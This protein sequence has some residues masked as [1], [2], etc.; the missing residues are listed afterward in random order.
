MIGSAGYSLYSLIAI[1]NGL[2]IDAIITLL[3]QNGAATSQHASSSMAIVLED[4]LGLLV[5]IG[6]ACMLSA[7]ACSAC[8]YMCPSATFSGVPEVMSY[9]NGVAMS[10]S[11]TLET[12]VYKF[13]S[14]AFAVSSGMPIGPEGPM[15]HIGAIIGRSI[16]YFLSGHEHGPSRSGGNGRT[17]KVKNIV[18][19]REERDF[20]IAGVGCGVAVAFGAPLGGLLFAFEE[21]SSG[22]GGSGISSGSSSGSGSLVWRTFLCCLCGV[23]TTNFLKSGEDYLL[24]ENRKF[25]SFDNQWSVA[26]EVH[27]LVDSHIYVVGISIFTGCVCGILGSL[28]TEG[29][30]RMTRMKRQ[31]FEKWEE[32]SVGVVAVEEER[33]RSSRLLKVL[34]V[35][36]VM[37]LFTSVSIL[38][39]ILTPCVEADC[40]ID[41]SGDY[42]CGSSK[43]T[44]TMSET[45]AFNQ[46]PKHAVLED[47]VS[48]ICHT[49]A[50]SPTSSS[51]RLMY[52]E[53]GT[54][55]LKSGH[56]TVRQLLSRETPRQFSVTVLVLFLLVYFIFSGVCCLHFEYNSVVEIIE[57]IS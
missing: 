9:L 38:L 43:T 26:Y 12:C 5:G 1:I 34:D 37:T 8:V 45:A 48:S 22:S 41:A 7:I 17:E 39:P 44:T 50:D 56:N 40:Y 24:Q 36:V 47:V 52:S 29:V 10:K 15:I 28:F 54:L 4:I 53:F 31:F 16:L 23:F 46:V 3:S 57:F 11:F 30:V 2:R 19:Q 32:G 55:F 13:F 49:A 20:I 33:R 42:S 14:N 18:S 25:G 27:K 6:A 21:V 51:P 35:M